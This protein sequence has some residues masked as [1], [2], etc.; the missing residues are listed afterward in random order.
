MRRTALFLALGLS[1]TALTA[2]DDDDG[3]GPEN[4]D[5]AAT[6]NG[7]NEIPAV[8]T[9]AVGF[10]TFEATETSIIFRIEVQNLT[11]AIGAHIH[12]GDD[13][14]EGPIIATLFEDVDGV[15][16]QNGVLAEG[17]IDQADINAALD[18]S[19]NELLEVLANSSAYVN[20][21]T[22]ANPDGEIRGQIG[23]Q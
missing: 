16:I 14:V 11:D 4:A 18:L 5:F 20:V 12:I 3:T 13:D 9:T 17:I 1:A 22:M 10:V 8:V 7:Q 2:C 6:L 15:D 21:H 23:P 19:F